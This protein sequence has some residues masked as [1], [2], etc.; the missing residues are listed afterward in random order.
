MMTAKRLE[1]EIIETKR[2]IN[3]NL[4]RLKTMKERGLSEGMIQTIEEELIRLAGRKEA[5]IQIY[6]TA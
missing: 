1:Y 3:V 2:R 6:T 4:R 5:L